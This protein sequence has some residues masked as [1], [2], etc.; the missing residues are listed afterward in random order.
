MKSKMIFVLNAN[1]SHKDVML[2]AMCEYKQKR[3][4]VYGKNKIKMRSHT[5]FQIDI[6]KST[7]R[8]LAV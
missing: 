6:L 1:N 8:H 5:Q 2:I 4:K 7:Q 3:N